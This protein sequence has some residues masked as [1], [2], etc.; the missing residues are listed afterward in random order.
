MKIIGGTVAL[1]ARCSRSF[2]VIARM[3]FAL[4]YFLIA[5]GSVLVLT[6]LVAGALHRN[7][8]HSMAVL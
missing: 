6:G 7:E 5:A 3:A 1:N 4:A 8:L 2:I